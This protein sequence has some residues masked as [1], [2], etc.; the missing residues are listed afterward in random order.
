MI[1]TN[2]SVTCEA[3]ELRPSSTAWRHVAQCAVH[4][5]QQCAQPAIKMEMRAAES[6]Q[7]GVR[8]G[9][10]CRLVSAAA[11]VLSVSGVCRVVCNQPMH[12]PWQSDELQVR[13]SVEETTEA[14]PSTSR[15][16]RSISYLLVRLS[17]RFPSGSG[18]PERIGQSCSM[19][20]TDSSSVMEMD[21]ITHSCSIHAMQHARRVHLLPW[22]WHFSLGCPWTG[23]RWTNSVNNR[24]K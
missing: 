9:R 17:Q 23:F 21:E 22:R 16:C 18:A 3:I 4:V 24:F 19:T 1:N 5:R 12:T 15:G 2:E 6:V 11:V 8:R 14:A 13:S 10:T 20:D 7:R